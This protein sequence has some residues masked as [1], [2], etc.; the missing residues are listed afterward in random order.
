MCPLCYRLSLNNNG[1]ETDVA[2]VLPQEPGALPAVVSAR[3]AALKQ[4]AQQ[5]QEQLQTSYIQG[6]EVSHQLREATTASARL[7]RALRLKER[8]IQS[9]KRQLGAAN[10]RVSK[11]LVV[12]RHENGCMISMLEHSCQQMLQCDAMMGKCMGT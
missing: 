4:Q 11:R 12:W 3:D 7:D 8:H 10:D 1:F 9:L 5:L 2:H 6:A